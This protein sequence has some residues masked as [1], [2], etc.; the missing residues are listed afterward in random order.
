MHHTDTGHRGQAFLS[1]ESCLVRRIHR[2][3]YPVPEWVHQ[4]VYP[5]PYP[6]KLMLRSHV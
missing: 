4:Q 3:R 1:F 5:H 2:N 6:R